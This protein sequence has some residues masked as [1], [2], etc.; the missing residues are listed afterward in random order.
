MSDSYGDEDIEFVLPQQRPAT[1]PL[2]REQ[3]LTSKAYDLAEKQIMAGNASSQIITHFLRVGSTTEFLNQEK[4]RKDI[5]LADAKIEQMKQGEAMMQLMEDAI[6]AMRSY[7]PSG[8]TPEV[9][10]PTEEDL[11]FM[12][13]E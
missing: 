12:E 9:I 5:E 11:Q 3:Q 1:T 13:D 6:S 10:M 2:E 7:G 8:S 4:T